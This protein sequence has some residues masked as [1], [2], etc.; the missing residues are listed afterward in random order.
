MTTEDKP[1]GGPLSVLAGRWCND[2]TF[3]TWLQ[4]I[5]PD[6]DVNPRTAAEWIRETCRVTS[7]AEIDHDD[8]ARV[9]FHFDIRIPFAEYKQL[10]ESTPGATADQ[11]GTSK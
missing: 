7:R 8:A 5:A 9:R 11:P 10:A 3:M 2:P 4:H 1:K 6:M